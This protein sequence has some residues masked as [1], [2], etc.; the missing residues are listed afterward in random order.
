MLLVGLVAMSAIRAARVEAR[1]A[2]DLVVVWAPGADSRPIAEAARAAGAAI[3]DRTP[4]PSAKER[5]VELI[6]QGR[7][8][9]PKQ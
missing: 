3:D 5:T 1:P 8:L 2:A 7:E 9:D 4:P 6:K